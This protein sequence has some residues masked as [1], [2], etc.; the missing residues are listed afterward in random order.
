MSKEISRRVFL[1][2][3]LAGTVGAGL[4]AC[5]IVPQEPTQVSEGSVPTGTNSRVEPVI[6]TPVPS[7]TLTSIPSRVPTGTPIPSD[8]PIP[9]ETPR[10]PFPEG[11]GEI[12][13]VEDYKGSTY[14]L[15]PDN[16]ARV[17]YD[18]EKGEWVKY[19]RPV[20]IA[21]QAE[22]KSLIPT[23]LLK[24]DV[25]KENIVRLKDKD[26]N[27]LKW[28]YLFEVDYL[29]TDN[30]DDELASGITEKKEMRYL[31][32]AYPIGGFRHDW[33]GS[34]G[35]GRNGYFIVFEIPLRFEDQIFVAQE[36]D[37]NDRRH[38]FLIPSSGNIDEPLKVTGN[39]GNKFVGWESYAQNTLN[40]DNSKPILMHELGE[41]LMRPEAVGKQMVMAFD[42]NEFHQDITLYSPKFGKDVRIVT[43]GDSIPQGLIDALK[44]GKL[45][46]EGRAFLHFQEFFLPEDLY[47]ETQTLKDY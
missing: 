23:S 21:A 5:G 39:L 37:Q 38:V 19:D 28:G 42:D 30:Q 47:P 26:G 45:A 3:V 2:A 1:K 25:P 9:S 16:L 35:P 33:D 41:A 7:S 13:A 44:E 8:A 4:A 34:E 24:V 12:V 18:R 31:V 6:K 46:Y 36:A 32:S 10:P 29:A 27:N 11:L 15:D 14:G 43:D 40:F 17:V 20:R 22:V